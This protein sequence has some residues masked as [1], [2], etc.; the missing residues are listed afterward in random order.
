MVEDRR[1]VVRR[2][3][4]P[5]PPGGGRVDHV[6][7]RT[8]TEHPAGQQ[9]QPPGGRRA[10]DQDEVVGP[11]VAQHAVQRR[12]P[13]GVVRKASHEHVRGRPELYR[14]A[15]E[16][17]H[18]DAL[19]VASAVGPHHRLRLL[20]AGDADVADPL[21]VAFERGAEQAG[22][23]VARSVTRPLGGAREARDLAI[24]AGP[25]HEVQ[26][27]EHPG[28]GVVRDPRARRHVEEHLPLRERPQGGAGHSVREVALGEV[29]E[30]RHL[31]SRGRRHEADQRPR[32]GAGGRGSEEA[33]GH[34][35]E[36]G[37]ES[38]DP[39]HFYTL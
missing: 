27:L 23:D 31:G 6:A 32:P 19:D 13:A 7:A 38:G 20:E 3:D 33:S 22:H 28:I 30:E 21:A 24:P 9:P 11:P 26:A 25:N 16:R 5:Q 4:Q 1:R 18:R 14:P 2:R 12:K 34:D 37:A 35:A 36:N 39:A 15:R 17:A 10:D 29:E 8:G